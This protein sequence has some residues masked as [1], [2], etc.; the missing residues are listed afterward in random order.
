MKR[1]MDL[2]QKVLRRTFYFISVPDMMLSFVLPLYCVGLG[3]SPLQTTGLF[4]VVSLALLVS[5]F[6][7]GNLCDRAGRRRVFC[8]GAALQAVSYAVLAFSKSA[9]PLY[10]AQVLNGLSAALLSVALYAMLSDDRG[11][12]FAVRQGEISGSGGRGQL[13]GVLIYWGISVF[14][15]FAVSWRYFLLV[16]AAL[17][18]YGAVTAGREL[19]E[20]K[21]AEPSEKVSISGTL[22]KLFS[23]NVLLSLGTSVV[24]VILMLYLNWAYSLSLATMGMVLLA[25]AALLVY[26]TPAIGKAVEKRGE[27]RM[28]F[29]GTA[30][31]AASLCA[32]A[33]W[34]ALPVFVVC[35]TLYNVFEK[36][37]ALSFDSMVSQRA[38]EEI[39][40]RVSGAYQ[41]S[42]SL[43]SFLGALASGAAFQTISAA[44]PFY[45][46]AAIF[47]AVL[48]ALAVLFQNPDFS[49]AEAVKPNSTGESE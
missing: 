45:L 4:S 48:I 15:K 28:F 8:T 7:I 44:A 46:A 19:Q 39:R 5:K 14:A 36:L 30:G 17:C 49:G 16:S 18:A 13:L 6:F 10:L 9:A 32:M 31:A 2:N 47:T 34:R 23:V 38:T 22:K 43:G 40:G 25:P 20:T 21:P 27:R 42:G 3:F 41:A 35:W 29:T 37:L 24:G 12:N 1:A 11:R 26:A 33:L